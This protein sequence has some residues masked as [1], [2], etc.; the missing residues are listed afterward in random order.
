MNCIEDEKAFW[1][2]LIIEQLSKA[3][4]KDVLSNLFSQNVTIH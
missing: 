2:L 3:N 4:G 1:G